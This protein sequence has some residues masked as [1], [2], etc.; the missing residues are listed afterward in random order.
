MEKFDIQYKKAAEL[1]SREEYANQVTALL[2]L[3]RQ[4]D[5][6]VMKRSL[7]ELKSYYDYAVIAVLEGEIIGNAT[8]HPAEMVQEQLLL[9]TGEKLKI[10]EVSS[11]VLKP[12]WQGQGI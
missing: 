10:G 4:R 5:K 9:P 12:E 8:C 1:L 2:E 7:E 3:S 11:V 6:S